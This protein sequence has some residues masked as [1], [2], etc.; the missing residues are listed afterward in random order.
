MSIGLVLGV[1]PPPDPGLHGIDMDMVHTF[2]FVGKATTN[3]IRLLM[4]LDRR[5]MQIFAA[6]TEAR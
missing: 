1:A 4:T 2:L 5:N 6:N 3:L